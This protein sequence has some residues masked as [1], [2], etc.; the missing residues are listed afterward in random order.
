MKDGKII[1][2]RCSLLALAVT[3]LVSPCSPATSYARPERHQVHSLNGAYF[4]DVNPQSRSHT[5]Y[6]AGAPDTPLWSFSAP[7]WQSPFFLS[8]DGRVAASLAWQHIRVQDIEEMGAVWFWDRTGKFQSYAMADLCP[9]PRRQG[10]FEVGPIGSFWRVWCDE[11]E[12]D[13]DTLRIRTTD[14]YEY[15]FSMKDGQIIARRLVWT[16]FLRRY[17]YYGAAALSLVLLLFV[18]VRTRRRRR[19]TQSSGGDEYHHQ[20]R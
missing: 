7:V 4:L 19:L 15:L 20:R 3:L 6:A 13:G 5:I 18:G 10:L 2:L 17:W 14:R 8:D 1:V 16:V 9:Y 11:V 12:Q